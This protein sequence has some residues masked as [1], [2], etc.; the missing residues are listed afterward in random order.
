MSARFLLPYDFHMGGFHEADHPSDRASAGH[1]DRNHRCDGVP[2][3]RL[4]VRWERLLRQQQRE[5]WP[6]R[7]LGFVR[8]HKLEKAKARLAGHA[9]VTFF[10]IE[11]VTFPWE[12]WEDRQGGLPR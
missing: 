4:C 10:A 12:Y 5:T 1:A 9:D 6:M 2:G 11:D 7:F 3:C 8:K